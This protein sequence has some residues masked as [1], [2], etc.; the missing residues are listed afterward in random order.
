M[1]ELYDIV[2][3]RKSVRTFDGRKL[4]PGDKDKIIQ[5]S[6]T[7]TNPFDIDVEFKFLD[8]EEFGLS[9]PVLAG[10][11]M[12]VSCIV[13]KVP[14]ADVA[15]GYS[16]EQLV[17][18]AWSLG[19]GTT[20]IGGTMKRADFAKASGLT[21]GKRMPI[22]SPLGYP[23]AKRAIKEVMMRKGVKADT[24]KPA[25]ELFFDGDLSRPLISDG[26][27]KK[28]LEIVRWAPSAVNKQPW[29][30]IFKDGKYHFYEKRDMGFESD[31]VGDM[32]KIDIGIA[33]CHFV[34]SLK[35]DGIDA[36]VVIDDPGIS[37]DSGMEYIATAEPQA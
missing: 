21:D 5:Y 8:A 35:E 31:P 9:S 3:G 6:E 26:I 16:F 28:A 14:Y 2:M 34:M 37:V 11:K 13:D 24:R 23:A 12:Y 1:A 22:I 25:E 29:R 15:L 20:W 17:L 30:I 27:I 4:S 36:A 19:V 33:L 32:Q 18:Y 7:V 10:E